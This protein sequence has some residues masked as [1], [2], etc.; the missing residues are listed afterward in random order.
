MIKFTVYSR[1]ITTEETIHHDSKHC[2]SKTSNFK[3]NENAE[4][5]TISSKNCNHLN[6]VKLQKNKSDN[7]ITLDIISTNCSISPHRKKEHESQLDKAADPLRNIFKFSFQHQLSISTPSDTPHDRANEN[8]PIHG[9]RA[10][11]LFWIILLNV[12]TMLSYTSSEIDIPS[13]FCQSN[14]CFFCR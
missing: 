12:T 1:A 7:T 10:F 4:S 3:M 5:L 13:S 14:L 6:L 11:S 9:I 2:R 8:K